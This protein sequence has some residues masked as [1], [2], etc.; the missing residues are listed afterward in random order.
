M[1]LPACRIQNYVRM[2]Q[3]SGRWENVTYPYMIRWRHQTSVVVDNLV[4]ELLDDEIIPDVLIEIFSHAGHEDRDPFAPNPAE[5]RI[6][7]GIWSEVVDDVVSDLGK[8]LAQQVIAAFVNTYLQQRRDEQSVT[9]DP[10]AVVA[11]DIAVEV[12]DSEVKSIVG[13]C[14]SE[15]VQAYLRQQ[16]AD[17]FL[18]TTLQPL[19]AEMA[20]LALDDIEVDVV[21]NNMVEDFILETSKDVAEEAFGEMQDTIF[22]ERQ[23]RQY[24]DVATAAKRIFDNTSLRMLVRTM[25][26]NSE[27]ILMR[28]Y[29]DKM[30][31]GM[32]STCMSV[33]VAVLC[34]MYFAVYLPL[35]PPLTPPSLACCSSQSFCQAEPSA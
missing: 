1:V 21:V 26:T 7:W 20:L 16:T 2:R 23:S 32:I 28:E 35:P 3:A 18:N 13:D 15:M 17:Q 22:G 34:G 30:A 29:M 8:G 14:I 11:E 4:E 9:M 27:N 12:A 5:D 33:C 24:T 31:S 25:A 6:V 19:I 10:S